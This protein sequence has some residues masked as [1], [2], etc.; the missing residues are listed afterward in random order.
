LPVS[1][2]RADSENAPLVSPFASKDNKT[3]S[4]TLSRLET[5]AAQAKSASGRVRKPSK[6]LQEGVASAKSTDKDIKSMQM[7]VGLPMAAGADSSA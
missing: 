6:T 3:D 4:E 2:A 1:R 5:T 7:H